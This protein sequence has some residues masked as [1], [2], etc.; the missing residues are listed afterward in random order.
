M[1]INL[2]KGQKVDLTKNNPGLTDITVG[3]GWDPIQK[4][5]KGGLFGALR[6]AISNIDCDASVLLLQNDRLLSENDIVSYRKLQSNCGSVNHSGDNLTGHGD[7]DDEQVFVTLNDLPSKYNKL[8]F[9]VNIYSAASRKQDFGMI[10][11]AYIRLLNSRSNEELIRYNLS[12]EYAG[13]TAL[14]LG[15]MYRYNGEWK[16]AAIGTGT[17]DGSLTEISKHY[18]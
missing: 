9:I 12:D 13:K 18:K 5:N 6:A 11:N 8:V 7:G 16:F 3:L 2:Q 15:E 17:E 1:P 4:A 14:I 10:Q